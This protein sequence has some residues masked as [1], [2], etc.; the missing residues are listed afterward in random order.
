MPQFC[1]TDLFVFRLHNT[2]LI[3]PLTYFQIPIQV[4]TIFRS[5]KLCDRM[6][7]SIMD[8]QMIPQH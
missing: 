4:Y 7:S 8:Q 1:A 6:V 5:L 2:L 3:G